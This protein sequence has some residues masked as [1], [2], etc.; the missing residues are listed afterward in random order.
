MKPKILKSF[1]K[2][3]IYNPYIKG[4]KCVDIFKLTTIMSRRHA[5]HFYVVFDEF[6]KVIIIMRAF[7]VPPFGIR[8]KERRKDCFK[9]FSKDSHHDIRIMSR[10]HAEY[11]NMFII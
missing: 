7:M 6:S 3:S 10:R 4:E 2:F 9:I 8:W 5:R 11:D 1:F